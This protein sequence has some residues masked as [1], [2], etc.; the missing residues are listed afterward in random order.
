MDLD[1]VVHVGLAQINLMLNAKELWFF[2]ANHLQLV[3]TLCMLVEN[4]HHYFLGTEEY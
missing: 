3:I 1:F 2:R 4:M